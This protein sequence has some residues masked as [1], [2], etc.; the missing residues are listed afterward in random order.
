MDYGGYDSDLEEPPEKKRLVESDMDSR[1]ERAYKK[2]PDKLGG[3][4]SYNDKES[5][6][7]QTYHMKKMDAYTRHKELIRNY[8]KHYGGKIEDFERNSSNDRNDFTVLQENHKFLWDSE[9]PK[10]WEQRIAKR[11]YDKLFKEYCIT[12]LSRY[13]S[14]KIALRWRIAA[15]VKS[16]KGQFICGNKACS[17]ED[18]LTSWEVNFGYVEDN[19]KKNALVKT[20]LC[21]DCSI[22][23]NMVKKVSK[24][25]KKKSKRDSKKHKKRKSGSKR[26]SSE[27]ADEAS[28]SVSGIEEDGGGSPGNVWRGPAPETLIKSNEDEMDEFLEDLLL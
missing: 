19:E 15:E 21:P 23:L 28:T 11:Y 5:W 3:F 7:I 22:K 13:E 20:R 10:N 18:L 24:V 25:P 17:E 9:D 6:K 12:D 4:T 8:V 2:N 26:R 14:R 16:G 27:A 1:M